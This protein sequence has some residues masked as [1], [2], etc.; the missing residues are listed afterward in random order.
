VTSSSPP[1]SPDTDAG[2]AGAGGPDEGDAGRGV[3]LVVVLLVVVLLVVVLLVV[4][5]L[6]VVL[7]VVVLLVVV[8]VAGVV[9]LAAT[10][11]VTG[12]SSIGTTGGVPPPAA[13]TAIQTS[14]IP[15]SMV[16]M[17]AAVA[18]TRP[19]RRGPA[20]VTPAV[21]RPHRWRT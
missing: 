20:V 6:V 9:V 15:T 13:C 19:N 7:L 18:R 8:V 16:T 1:T 21:S 14:A 10:A 5:L 4:V 3:T 12:C 2:G 11:V 17:K